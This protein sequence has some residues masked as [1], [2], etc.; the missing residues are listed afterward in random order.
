LADRFAVAPATEGV[1][2]KVQAT[3]GNNFNYLFIF[4]SAISFMCEIVV[5]SG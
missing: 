2:A 4:K 3:R 5:P 1:K